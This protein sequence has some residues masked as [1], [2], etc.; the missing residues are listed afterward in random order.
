M[1]PSESSSKAKKTVFAIGAHPDD[2]EFYMS[3]T[4]ML[5][6]EAGYELHYMNVANGCCGTTQYDRDTISKMRRAE[7]MEAAKSVGAV[8]HESVCNDLEI[9]YDKP[10]L[11]RL[12]SVVREVAP[13]ILLT[14]PPVDYMEDHTNTCR[15]V[16]TA[17]FAR[18]AP[19]FEVDPPRDAVDTQVTVYHSQPYPNRDPLGQVV[20]PDIFVD[21]GDLVAR[22]TAMLAKH[23]SQKEWLDRSQGQDSYLETSRRLDREVGELSGEFQYAEGWR[24]HLHIGFCSEEDRPLEDALRERTRCRQGHDGSQ[25][26][27]NT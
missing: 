23:K 6:G 19:N 16:V 13:T 17:A 7:A 22:K 11:A 8:F 24:R 20:R 14:H 5:L 26:A 3:G 12:G 18:G 1:A 9:F 15:L 10:T 21:V 25:A 4:F 2:I 27:P